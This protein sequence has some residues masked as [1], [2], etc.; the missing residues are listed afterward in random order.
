MTNATRVANTFFK[1]IYNGSILKTYNVTRLVLE[2]KGN[3]YFWPFY[4]MTGIYLLLGSNLGDKVTH[5]ADARKLITQQLG[6]IQQA[7][8]QYH[9]EPWG[10][11]NAPEFLNQVIVIDSSID[12][13]EVL[14]KVLNI[15]IVL[16]RS[17]KKDY[18]NRT[19]DIDL[20]YYGKLVFEHPS[21][22]IPHP[23]ISE[24]KFVLT[25]LSEIAP[26]F[27]HPVLGLTNQH[28]LDICTDPLS[29]TLWEQQ[30][31]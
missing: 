8:S 13:L 21:L 27:V 3:L 28:L 11:S 7:S 15:E 2:V 30:S 23:R 16:G 12:P 25:P 29:V 26:D 6:H 10:M 5:L 9:T 17:R 18:Q 24:R 22:S 4:W 1:N 31:N 14:D 19:I 20:L